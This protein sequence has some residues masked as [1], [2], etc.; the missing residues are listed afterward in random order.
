MRPLAPRS[1][2]PAHVKSL[3]A[4]AD[5]RTGAQLLARLRESLTL[6]WFFGVT[7]GLLQLAVLAVRRLGMG[8]LVFVSREAV[9]MTP[10]AFTAFFVPLA[11]VLALVPGPERWVGR[12]RVGVFVFIGGF[13]LLLPFGQIARWAAALVA[14]GAAVQVARLY[15][16]RPGFRRRI[17][18]LAAGASLVIALAGVGQWAWRTVRQQSLIAGLPAAAAASPN[19]LIIILDTV[20]GE[21]MSLYGYARPTTPALERHAA[22]AAVFDRAIATAPWTL[23]T[24]GTLLTGLY[25]GETG[26]DFLVPISHSA[27][28]LPEAFQARG[29]RT[30]GF[31]ANLLYTSWESGLARGFQE[32]QDYRTSPR[33]VLTHSVIGQTGLVNGLLDA[34]SPRALWRTLRRAQLSVSRLP[35]DIP[36]AAPEI[37][38]AFLSWQAQIEE[39]PFFAF[40]NYFDAH[41]PYRAP[42]ELVARFDGARDARNRY[43]AAIAF[44]DM[45]L[46]RLLG[47]MDRRGVLD[48]TI[49]VITGDH[50]EL[51]GEHGL[52]GHA[53]ALFLPL[54]RVPLLIR[55]PRSV[56]G[57]MRITSPVTLRDVPATVL[58]LAGISSDSGFPGTSLTNLW[59]A[60]DSTRSAIVAEVTQGVNVDST[61]PN[62]RTGLGSVVDGRYHYIRNGFGEEQLFDWVA[63]SME[64]RD[65]AGRPEGSDPLVR[66]RQVLD[67]VLS[68]R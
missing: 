65:L 51:F 14:L 42:P 48:N 55:Y 9:W 66:L 29:Y 13:F 18:P 7:A 47:E 40:L 11:F 16:E 64:V 59:M 28:S 67:S 3:I 2:D 15:T 36:V 57:G 1:L 50:G 49:V 53:N 6:A 4:D 31:V 26:G 63:D 62:A 20:R 24:H 35:A 38:D 68:R 10:L 30:A 41:G 34:R 17:L 25:A 60:Q 61:F 27:R 52:N 23:P 22:D 44:L 58:A 5:D 12:V 8:Q 45:E 19:V 33:L 32:Y 37:T 56:P 21:N 39:R 43:D 54:L 46:D